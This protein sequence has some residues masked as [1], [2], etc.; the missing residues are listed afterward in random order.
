[1]LVRFRLSPALGYR[2]SSRS[3]LSRDL[4]NI[5][6]IVRTKADLSHTRAAPLQVVLLMLADLATQLQDLQE[7]RAR[8][9]TIPKEVRKLVAGQRHA[10]APVNAL[11]PMQA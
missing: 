8:L 5:F 4:P 1:M 2:L 6:H 7:A 10:P 9:E 11:I 3:L